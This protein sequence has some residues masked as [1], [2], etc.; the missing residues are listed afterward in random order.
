M[1][2]SLLTPLRNLQDF[3]HEAVHQAEDAGEAQDLSSP[4]SDQMKA[5][6][7][8]LKVAASTVDRIAVRT[9]YLRLT[10]Y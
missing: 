8:E 6:M 10:S 7:E 1:L 4:Q 2:R 5:S 9:Y 3:T